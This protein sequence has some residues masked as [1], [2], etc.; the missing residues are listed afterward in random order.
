MTGVLLAC[1]VSATLAAEITPDGDPVSPGPGKITA[2]GKWKVAQGEIDGAVRIIAAPSGGGGGMGSTVTA[3]K[4]G[5]N[6]AGTVENL[7]P[8]TEYDVTIYMEY[9][10][11]AGLKAIYTKTYKVKTK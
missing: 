9:F 3:Q 11:K 6:Y 10:D 1:M 7:M 5:G 8:M 4:I 2:T